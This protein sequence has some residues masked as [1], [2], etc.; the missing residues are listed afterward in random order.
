MRRERG[1]A[2]IGALAVLVVLGSTGAVMIRM[3]GV[4][5]A[6]ASAAVLGLRAD[7]AARAG[8]EWAYHES[9]RLAGCPPSPTTLGLSEGGL[10]GFQ[11]VVQCSEST[12][13]EGS[14]E[15][16]VLVIRSESRFGAVGARDFVLREIQASLVL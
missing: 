7:W 12:H 13:A 16:S 4:Q 15:R 8:I 2:L 3:S 11:V 1:F 14:S 6:G 5:Q 9:A 10:S